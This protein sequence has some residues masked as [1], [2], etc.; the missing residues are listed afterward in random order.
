MS[1]KRDAAGS[2]RIVV[3]RADLIMIT[4]LEFEPELRNA[5]GGLCGYCAMVI[6]KGQVDHFIPV[7]ILRGQEK[8]E[9]AYE[10]SNYR[11]GE[12]SLNQRKWKHKVLTRPV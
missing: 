8:D 3:T 2:A 10:W 6:F 4:G 5:F 12:A 1:E 9:L 11:Y 7:A